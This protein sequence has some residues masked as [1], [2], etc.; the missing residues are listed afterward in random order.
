MV[1]LWSFGRIAVEACR[2]AAMAIGDVA[3]WF[4]ALGALAALYFAGRQ[5][6]LLREQQRDEREVEKSGVAVMWR[7][8]DAPTTSDADGTV[9]ATYEFTA[10]NPGK[11]PVREVE[12]RVDLPI[13][14]RRE[15]FDRSLEGPT[16]T[17]L[18]DTPVIAGARHR[19]W[20]RRLRVP[21]ADR[22]KLRDLQVAIT[23][24][25]LAGASHTNRWGRGTGGSSSRSS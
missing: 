2:V 24:L 14:V 18:I 19:T 8:L 23:F 9:A 6:Q 12:V 15:H 5:L 22:S 4:A 20:R 17:L 1:V 10:Y 7:V 13:E 11:F 25:D 21:F 3:G 16:R